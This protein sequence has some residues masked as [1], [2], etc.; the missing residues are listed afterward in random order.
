MRR[1]TNS[2]IKKPKAEAYNNAQ[3]KRIFRV[4]TKRC[5]STM[6][7]FAATK[8]VSKVKKIAISASLIVHRQVRQGRLLCLSFIRYYRRGIDATLLHFEILVNY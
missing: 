4:K 1:A 2:P 5:V 6:I 3:A 7:K 8:Y